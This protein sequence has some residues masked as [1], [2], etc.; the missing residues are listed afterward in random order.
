MFETQK[1]TMSFI[2]SVIEKILWTS[3]LTGES[4][5]SLGCFAHENTFIIN[6]E[7]ADRKMI[8][9]SVPDV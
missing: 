3:V 2:T 4:D 9:L 1:G 8:F 7:I 5:E 6:T